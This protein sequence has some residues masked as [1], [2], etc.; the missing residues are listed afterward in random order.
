[1]K[2]FMIKHLEAIIRI[3]ALC[4]LALLIALSVG[5]KQ[6]EREKD[7]ASSTEPTHVYKIYDNEDPPP[8]PTTT[9][10]TETT[11]EP[12]PEETTETVDEL[13]TL[14]YPDGSKEF[15]YKSEFEKNGGLEYYTFKFFHTPNGYKYK[16]E[17]NLNYAYV[18][19]GDTIVAEGFTDYWYVDDNGVIGVV[20][21]DVPYRSTY[22]IL[23][24]KKEIQEETQEN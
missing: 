2:K 4:L 21:N 10:A 24:T 23:L 14:E 16:L 17:N 3:V 12:N 18:Y 6:Q 20:I 15:V 8:Q 9:V 1:M 22:G 7:Y 19:I 13:Y 5:C 11:A